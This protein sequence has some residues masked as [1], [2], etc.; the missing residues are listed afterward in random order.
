MTLGDQ[1]LGCA[2]NAGRFGRLLTSIERGDPRGELAPRAV[3]ETLRKEGEHFMGSLHASEHAAIS[4]FPLLALCDRILLPNCAR[5]QRRCRP[6][7][8]VSCKHCKY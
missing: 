8:A 1:K 4:L 2:P 6:S 3:E 7:A 5:Y